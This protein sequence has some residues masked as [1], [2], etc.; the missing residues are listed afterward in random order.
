MAVFQYPFVGVGGGQ[1][2]SVVPRC[3]LSGASALIF[4]ALWFRLAGLTFGN[5]VLAAAIVLASFMGGLAFGNTL[6]AFRGHKIKFPIR[7]Y[8]FLEVIIAV[9]GC[10]L[11]VIFPNLTK[12]LAPAFRLF[13]D[14][15]LTL[16]FFRAIT[17]FLLMLVPTTAMGAT[18]PVLVK[19]LYA[20]K[21]NF[22]NALGLLYG[23]NTLGALVG[24]IVCE[25]FFVKWFV[26]SLS[27]EV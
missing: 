25:M 14:Q 16:N 24:V 11:V 8:A 19:A 12:I 6:V 20:K 4:E 1:F 22:G 7:L 10:L 9:S 5:S 3:F 17:L 21:R 27:K 2:A 23:F 26:F 18:L 13:L 15:P